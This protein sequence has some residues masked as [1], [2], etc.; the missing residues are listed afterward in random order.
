MIKVTISTLLGFATL[1]CVFFAIYV[2]VS[3]GQ[4]IHGYDLPV[5][6]YWAGFFLFVAIL[7]AFFCIWS[8]F[9]SFHGTTE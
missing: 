8:F 9:P 6:S 5:G 3:V 7:I 1:P 2:A 4:L